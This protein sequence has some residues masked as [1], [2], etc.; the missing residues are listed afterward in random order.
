LLREYLE[1]KAA[2]QVEHIEEDL[3]A[4]RVISLYLMNHYLRVGKGQPEWWKPDHGQASPLIDELVRK[5]WDQGPFAV[6]SGWLSRTAA[7]SSVIELGCG[8]GG[9][10]SAIQDRCSSYL[11][12]DGSF[13]SIALARHVALGAKYAAKLRIPRDLLQGPVSAD[14]RITPVRGADGRADFIVGEL[15]NLPVEKGEWGMSIALNAIDMLPDPA[16]LPRLQLALVHKGGIA[17]QSCPYIW[18]AEVS[19]ELRKILPKTV[20][21]SAAAVEWIYEKEGFKLLER[22]DHVPWLFYKHARQLE[23]YSVHMILAEKR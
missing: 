13:A 23:V 18:H 4:E 12:V 17:I 16:S 9:L 20:K 19:A 6:I 1:A 11:G 7:K 8:V 5:H 15:E 2:I 22:T 21:D 3:E 10:Y 14:P